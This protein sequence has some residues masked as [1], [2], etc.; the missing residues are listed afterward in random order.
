VES[1][2]P[3]V[4]VGVVVIDRDFEILL[5]NERVE[6]LW[7]LKEDEVTGRSLLASTSACW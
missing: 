7:G 2:L 5:W 6:D 3:S 4:E 1:I